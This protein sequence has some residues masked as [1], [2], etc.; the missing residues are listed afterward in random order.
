MGDK[1]NY[2]LLKFF[3][4]GLSE[5]SDIKY[6]LNRINNEKREF[7]ADNEEMYEVL[8][9]GMQI[10]LKLGSERDIPIE[11]VLIYLTKIPIKEGNVL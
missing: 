10:K 2:G 4:S 6:L 5:V 8:I 1:F 3:S 11:E 9:K 7:H